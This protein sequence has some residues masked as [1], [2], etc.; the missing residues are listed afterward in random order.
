MIRTETFLPLSFD[1]SL[2]EALVAFLIALLPAYHVYVTLTPG[3]ETAPKRVLVAV[4]PGA[5][6]GDNRKLSKAIMRFALRFCAPLAAEDFRVRPWVQYSGWPIGADDLAAYWRRAVPYVQITSDAFSPRDWGDELP[7][8]FKGNTLGDRLA[9]RQDPQEELV[10]L[11]LEPVDVVVLADGPLRQ[12]RVALDQRLDR[13][14]HHRLDLR[15]H[16]QDLL[17][18]GLEL[19]LVLVIGVTFHPKRPVM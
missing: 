8:I 15:P 19:A 4:D 14:A 9:P 5:P 10:G 1:V 2:S 17:P 18:D 16:E 6:D 3:T 12:R 13:R 11:H 7:A